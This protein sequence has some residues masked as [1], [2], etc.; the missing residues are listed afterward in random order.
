MRH[1]F[2]GAK[3]PIPG[4]HRGDIDWSLTKRVLE[5]AGI[6]RDEWEQAGQ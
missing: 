2:T 5:E 4:P 6:R 3:I 1:P